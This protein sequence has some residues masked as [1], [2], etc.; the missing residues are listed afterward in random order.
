MSND[1]EL[2]RQYA[3]A[4]AEDSF[5]ELVRRHLPLVHSAALRQVGGDEALAKDVAQTVFIDLT[6]KA[7]SLSG[8]MLLT[9][10]LYTSTRFA[11]SNAVRQEQR[12]KAREQ[13]AM[14]LQDPLAGP[15]AEPAWAALSPVL[16]E[17]MAY[18]DVP[19]RDAVLLR[20]F[21]RKEFKAVGLALGVSED[22]ARMRVNRAL[23]RLRTLLTQRGVAFSATALG[24]TLAAEAVRAAPLELATTISKAALAAAASAGGVVASSRGLT[25][26]K[27]KV[28]LAGAVLAAGIAV[29]L[30]MKPA[31]QGPQPQP[32]PELSQNAAAVTPTTTTQAESPSEATETPLTQPA[33]NEGP[34]QPGIPMPNMPG[35]GMPMPRP[36]RPRPGMPRR[37]PGAMTPEIATR[38]MAQLQGAARPPPIRV[39]PRL[40]VNPEISVAGELARGGITNAAVIKAMNKVHRGAFPLPEGITNAADRTTESR[41][42]VAGVAECLELQPTDRVL[43]LG[44]GSGYE[45]A[46]LAQLAQ[47]VYSVEPLPILFNQAKANLANSGCT[48]VFVRQGELPAGWPEASLFDK[49]VFNGTPEQFSATLIRQLRS[50]GRLAVPVPED[51]TVQIFEKTGDQLTLSYVRRLG[52]APVRLRANSS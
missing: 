10:W 9:G 29:P 7:A 51:N 1:S 32:Q 50:G 6:R 16:D 45:A 13:K 43:D 36:G 2:L 27:A 33:P 22:A 8:R 37:P 5:A 20:F 52:L 15:A 39:V 11:A 31:A 48:N 23:E 40:A 44:T 41:L 49:M 24:S 25:M 28:A 38:Q 46:V 47:S 42:F 26:S 18:L 14:G 3:E 4:G 12:R 30:L 21:E 17:A 34:A 19:D 35:P